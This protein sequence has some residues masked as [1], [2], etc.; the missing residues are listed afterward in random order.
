MGTIFRAACLLLVLGTTNPAGAQDFLSLDAFEDTFIREFRLR[1]SDIIV[2]KVDTLHLEVQTREGK[3]I[4]I[5]LDNAY[6][7]YQT[8]PES[9]TEIIAEHISVL[10][11]TI[12][13][14]EAPVDITRIV[15]VIKHKDFLS[16]SPDGEWADARLAMAHEPFVADL[17]ILF[18]EDSEL[19][20]RYMGE[21]ILA[22]S[23]FPTSGRRAKAIDN[24][25][26]VLPKVEARGRDGIF[27]LSTGSGYGA[28]LVLFDEF[29]RSQQLPVKGELVVAI[30]SRDILVVT[31]S[32]DKEGL[33]RMGRIV[34]DVMENE[35]YTITD[36][37]LVYRDGQFVPFGN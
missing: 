6:K 3:T 1:T 9:K 23:G 31:G 17:V 20:T 21:G 29:W 26:A 36:R 14:V 34:S 8:S 35:A 5:F 2:R 33:E 28:S 24:L 10:L 32:K 13:G 15:P 37:L 11:K 30:P 18:A 4:Q 12:P 22:D 7:N 16:T 27:L 19:S 25:K